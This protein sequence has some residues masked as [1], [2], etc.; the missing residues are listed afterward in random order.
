MHVALSYPVCLQVDS[1]EIDSMD[2]AQKASNKVAQMCGI[3]QLVGAKIILAHG[4]NRGCADVEPVG[5]S[6][7]CE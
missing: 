3:T 2:L 7:G 6:F 5:H 1:L 4:R